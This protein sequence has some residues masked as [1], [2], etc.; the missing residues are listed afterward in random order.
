M[1]YRIKMCGG[2]RCYVD[3]K[4]YLVHYMEYM[5]DVVK[6][7]HLLHQRNPTYV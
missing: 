3:F 7:F 1:Q 4:T 5:Y 2:Y 6:Y